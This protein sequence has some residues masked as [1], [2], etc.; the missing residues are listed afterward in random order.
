[1]RLTINMRVQ[2][3]NNGDAAFSQY[4]LSIGDGVAGVDD[5]IP[6]GPTMVMKTDS[7]ADFCESI[8]PCLASNN[9]DFE[10][11]VGRAILS[12]KHTGVNIIN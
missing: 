11:L 8:F 1:M 4:L 2:R 6:L 3:S 12:P 10:Y 5:M 7:L 9:H